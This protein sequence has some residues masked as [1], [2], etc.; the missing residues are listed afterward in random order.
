[1][2]KQCF[3]ILIIL[4]LPLFAVAQ[5]TNGVIEFGFNSGVNLSKVSDSRSNSELAVGFNIGTS[6]DYFFS[7]R[8]SLKFKLVYDQKGW[9]NGF[10]LDPT[11]DPMLPTYV[12]TDFNLDYL[13]F[14]IMANWHFGKK[15]NWYLNF[16]PYAGFL[17]GAQETRF[18]SNLKEDFSP[19]DFGISVGI[20]VKI[21]LSKGL[22]ISFEYEGQEGVTNIFKYRSGSTYTNSRSSFNVGIIFKSK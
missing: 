10:V 15:R 12:E 19:T 9:D 5:N 3:I 22:K 17:V 11:T 4:S 7:N 1:M 13:T 8:W 2:T 20:G 18:D 14:P 16:G 21:P 6:V